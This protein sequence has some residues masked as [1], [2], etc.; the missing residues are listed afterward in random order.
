MPTM[1]DKDD[2]TVAETQYQMFL[3]WL[4]EEEVITNITEDSAGIKFHVGNPSDFSVEGRDIWG[5]S[6]VHTNLENGLTAEWVKIQ[7]LP[8]SKAKDVEY[9]LM[10][11][12][13]SFSWFDFIGN[14]PSS[15]SQM[16]E[17]VLPYI[18]AETVDI[19]EI[20]SALCVCLRYHDGM[21]GDV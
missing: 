21:F 11:L 9:Y 19:D 10:D 6:S 13:D 12:P 20:I 18:E 17:Y 14:M 5:R 15:T 2:H 7:V 8:V 4:E 3:S 1:S 16:L